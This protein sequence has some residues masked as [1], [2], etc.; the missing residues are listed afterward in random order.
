MYHHV[1]SVCALARRFAVKKDSHESYVQVQ[2][3]QRRI[4]VDVLEGENVDDVTQNSHLG[5]FAL[6]RDDAEVWVG[7]VEGEVE[8]HIGLDVR[9]TPRR[10][11][12]RAASPTKFH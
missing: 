2:R 5:S 10:M 12:S 8:V 6:T 4:T 11:T 1:C 3:S 9:V 7:D